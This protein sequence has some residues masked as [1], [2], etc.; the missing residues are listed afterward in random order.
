MMRNSQW[1]RKEM[2]TTEKEQ[3]QENWKGMLDAVAVP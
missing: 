1:A 2:G 3:K